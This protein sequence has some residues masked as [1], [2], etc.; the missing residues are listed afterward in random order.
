MFNSL[1]PTRV[2]GVQAP[3]QQALDIAKLLLQ[4]GNPFLAQRVQSRVQSVQPGMDFSKGSVELLPVYR[5]LIA[6]LN[7]PSVRPITPPIGHVGQRPVRIKVQNAT[8]VNYKSSKNE[9]GGDF[10]SLQRPSLDDPARPSVASS[11]CRR[12]AVSPCCRAVLDGPLAHNSKRIRGAFFPGFIQVHDRLKVM[13]NP[14][15]SRIARRL[16]VGLAGPTQGAAYS[17]SLP[18]EIENKQRPLGTPSPAYC[19]RNCD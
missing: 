9:G 13:D 17:R 2:S 11:P 4:S 5:C 14:V 12:V 10:G 3:F 1:V 7:L 6:H 18:T 15:N 16:D 19:P 8:L